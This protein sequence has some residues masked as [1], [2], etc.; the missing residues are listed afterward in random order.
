MLC[1]MGRGETT[2]SEVAA[3]LNMQQ[4][5]VSQQLVRLKLNGLVV[6]RREGRNVYYAL[7]RPEVM[8]LI[9]TLN[10]VFCKARRRTNSGTA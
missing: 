5:A 10:E 8:V 3:K 6:S 2:V 7:S 4:A 9:E 1:L